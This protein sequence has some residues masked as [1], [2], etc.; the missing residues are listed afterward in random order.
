[1]TD[2]EV[3]DDVAAAIPGAAGST[4]SRL[5]GL[6]GGAWL[7]SPV[8]GPALVVCEASDCDVQAAGAAAVAGVGPTVIAAPEGWLV[9]EHLQGQHV[10]AVELSRPT[11]LDELADLLRRWHQSDVTLTEAPLGPARVAYLAGIAPDALPTALKVDAAR[12]DACETELEKASG[13]HVPAH[14]DVVANLLATPRGLRLIDFEYAAAADPAR[15][16]GQVAWEAELDPRGLQ[17]LVRAYGADA[18]VAVEATASWAW[19][20]GVT[21]TLWAMARKGDPVFERYARRSWERVQRHWGRQ[22]D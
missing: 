21:W 9:V 15:E 20:T 5:A 1:M 7:M 19:V 4:W 22:G 13:G 16:L 8:H 10:S 17:R 14:L 6:T 18:G 2:A 11:V 12:A 3:P